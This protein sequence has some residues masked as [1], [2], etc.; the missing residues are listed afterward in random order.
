MVDDD[1]KDT[2]G[3]RLT[4][5]LDQKTLK[6]FIYSGKEMGHFN[7]I[8][9]YKGNKKINGYEAT[10]LIDICDAFLQARKEIKLS[11]RQKIIADQCEILVRSFAKVGLI[12]LIDEATGYQYD[13][14]KKE[15]QV[16]FKELVS[17]EILEYQK[18]FHISFYREIYRLWNIPFTP[19]NI[20]RKPQFVGHLTNKYV[21]KNLPKGIFVLEKLKS[22][23]PRTAKGNF[24]YRLHQSLTEDKGREALKKVLYTVEALAS[25][26]KDKKDFDKL[27]NEKYGQKEIPFLDLERLDEPKKELPQLSNFNKKL[28][29]GLEFNPKEKEV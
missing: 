22:N 19:K 5:Y 24:K 26:S 13:R 9:C 15:L 14:E 4:R 10:I 27:M 12:A 8:I 2:A 11:T 6:P 20:R 29:Q 25:V 17:D 23:T 21:Y 1:G 18:Q 28:K 3:T 7:P 16:I